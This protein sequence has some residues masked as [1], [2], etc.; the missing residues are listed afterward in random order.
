M[1]QAKLDTLKALTMTLHCGAKKHF[2]NK[3]G[4][5]PQP[6][7]LKNCMEYG[8]RANAAMKSEKPWKLYFPDEVIV[9]AVFGTISGSKCLS[10]H[11]TTESLACSG[12]AKEANLDSH[13]GSSDKTTVGGVYHGLHTGSD[14][15]SGTLKEVV[16]RP[17]DI[18]E[19][20]G[21]LL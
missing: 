20:N 12:A 11:S 16:L 18:L 7:S 10:T 19:V 2:G 13:L 6:V 21:L 3:G 8:V 14:Y 15:P 17:E 5:T 4:P 9:V 1:A